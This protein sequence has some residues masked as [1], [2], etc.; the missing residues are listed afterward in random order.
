MNSREPSTDSPR[1]ASS[2]PAVVPPGSPRAFVTGTGYVCQIVGVLLLLVSG[3]LFLFSDLLVTPVG[4][5]VRHWSEHLAGARLPGAL[6]SLAVLLGIVGGLALATAGIGLQGERRS[7]ARLG[8]FV[9]AA[10]ALGFAAIAVTLC[11]ATDEWLAGVVVLLGGGLM[12]VL[13]MLIGHSAAL[14]RQFPPP[15]D[16]NVVTEEWLAEHRRQREE[17]RRQ[18]DL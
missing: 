1:A 7:A 12:L 2:D 14:L 3:T 4:G 18:S 15:P 5:P 13:A 17:R 10:L 6:F 16:M 8:L 11:V 9:S